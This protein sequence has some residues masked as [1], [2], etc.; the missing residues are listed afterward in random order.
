MDKRS[1]DILST[2]QTTPANKPIHT[3][4]H[5]SRRPARFCKH[6]GD[7]LRC[8]P[9]H[10]CS[11]APAASVTAAPSANPSDLEPH[12][13][14]HYAA[15]LEPDEPYEDPEPPAQTI[16]EDFIDYGES[17]KFLKA[18]FD[19]ERALVTHHAQLM[20][21]GDAEKMREHLDVV[22]DLHA[23]GVLPAV[24]TLFQDLVQEMVGRHGD[25]ARRTIPESMSAHPYTFIRV[26]SLRDQPRPGWLVD[27]VLMEHGFAV[28]YG[29]PN[30]GK[31]FV[32]L[33][34]ALSMVHGVDWQGRPTM[35]SAVGYVAAEGASGLG[36]RLAAWHQ[37]HGCDEEDIRGEEF[38][39]LGTA[40]ELM[41]EET[42]TKLAM[43]TWTIPNLKLIVI[44][45]MARTI[46]GG[47]ENSAEDVGK[48]IAN[49]EML[50]NATDAAILIV[51]HT[52][53]AENSNIARGSSAL[54]GAATTMMF[55][56]SPK[57][58]NGAT[59]LSC[60]KQ[61]EAAPFED[62]ALHRATV[63]LDDG[64]TSCVIEAGTNLFPQA[65]SRTLVLRVLVDKFGADGASHADW[66]KETGIPSSTL[67]AAIRSLKADDYIDKDEGH[68]GK[69]TP[70]AKAPELLNMPVIDLSQ[71]VAGHD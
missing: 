56:V 16:E 4:R 37:A 36:P 13:E 10:A 30:C 60:E 50:R 25:I 21:S 47:D 9:D 42:A 35:K 5:R 48:F 18:L 66:L 38:Y 27:Q 24:I 19:P 7:C 67:D 26:A 52:T 43:A 71:P 1:E 69:Y 58:A 49:V 46:V 11:P 23:W 8:Y 55:L 6:C 54:N 65:D 44:D 2:T 61:K 68:R 32:A 57:A 39:V 22:K 14:A 51:H 45:T 31:S 41:K 34:W 12:E 20:V 40:P 64:E 53:K 70:T 17:E 15:L 29:Q 3:R 63:M 62:I 59:K 33:D 28:I